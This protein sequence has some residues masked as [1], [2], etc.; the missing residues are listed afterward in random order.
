MVMA[1]PARGGQAVPTNDQAADQTP[2]EIA[3]A[4]NRALVP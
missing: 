4:E 3:D 2:Q 1:V